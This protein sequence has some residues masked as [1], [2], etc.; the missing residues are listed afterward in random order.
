[1]YAFQIKYSEINTLTIFFLFSELD[2]MELPQ[3]QI[4]IVF[5]CL[6]GCEN[7]TKILRSRYT[8]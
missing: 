2:L 6:I 5:N 4:F 3:F 8:I 7:V 1:M